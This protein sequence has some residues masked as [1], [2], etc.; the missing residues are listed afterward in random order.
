MVLSDRTINCSACAQPF[1]FTAGEQEF[2]VAKGLT[3]QPKR[4]PN[5]RLTHKLRRQGK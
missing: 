2:F 4:C 5:C 3:N 1:L